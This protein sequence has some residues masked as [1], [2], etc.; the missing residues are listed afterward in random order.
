M[1]YGHPEVTLEYLCAWAYFH[2]LAHANFSATASDSQT[3][4]Q[5][6]LTTECTGTLAADSNG[7]VYHGRNMDQVPSAVR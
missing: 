6:T 2:E 1:K 7:F 4:S 3:E 5:E